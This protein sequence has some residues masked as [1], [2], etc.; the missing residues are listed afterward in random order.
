MVLKITKETLENN[1]IE[2]IIESV[3]A[4]WLN[5]KNMEEKLGHKNLPVISNK[6]GKIYKKRRCE[7]INKPTKQSD[8]RF[9]HND[10]AL[11]IIMDCRTDKSCSLKKNLGFKLH[12]VI[13]TKEQTIIN[14]IK[15]TF[16]GENMQ[17]QYSVLGYRI[18]LYFHEYKL[19][20]EVD[21]LGHTNRNINNEIERQKA[22]EKE[23]NCIFIRINPDEKDFNIFKEI[24]TNT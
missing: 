24:K 10:L 8:R 12:N 21:E 17:T 11:K 20:I 5:E 1:A 15:D 13:N 9:L 3:N 4:L 2:V 22:L 14:S 19:A 7:L 6:Y 18:D 16:E 23:L